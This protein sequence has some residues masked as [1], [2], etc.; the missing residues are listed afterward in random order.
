[1]SKA[2]TLSAQAKELNVEQYR[3]DFPILD[4][5]VNGKP[6]A[7]LD[8]A[9]TTQKPQQVIDTLNWY[10]T[11][12]NSNVHRGIHSLSQQASE[13]YE[14]VRGKLQRFFNAQYKE[15][16]VFVRGTTEGINL[17]AQTHGKQNVKEGDE[18]LITGMEHHSNIVPWQMLCEE[19]GAT[20]KVA[21]VTD[22]G[23]IDLDDFEAKLS[24]RTRMVAFIHVSNTLGTVN[25]ARYLVDRAHA[26]G[27]AV[28]IDG[29]Q[30]PMHMPVDVQDLDCDFYVM[31]AHKIFG[32]TGIGI[33]YGKYDVLDAMPPYQG[34]GDMI[35]TVTFEG[36]SYNEV[37]LKLEAGTPNIADTIAFGRAVEYVEGIGREAI[38][39]YE[40][41]LLEYATAA[42][43]SVDGL[44]VIGQS[45]DKAAV[46]SFV[47]DEIHPQDVGILLDQEGVAIRTGHHCTQPLMRRYN[48][49]A[50]S[51]A[52]F[53]FYNTKE[54]ID[55]LV[56]AIHQVKTIFS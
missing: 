9:A 36:T 44:Q 19:Q 32:P 35:D 20:L 54:E 6:L 25:P 50:T 13:A 53:A 30:A 18:V 45:S 29:A 31:S 16:M 52:S 5:E 24:D 39:S 15:E 10:Y 37:P 56:K 28:L 43:R 21:D 27:A 40:K 55:Q 23:D 41:E 12:V 14:Q 26:K 4:Q 11:Q 17:V 7:Y 47:F 49:P 38:Q 51:R 22:E 42:L 8:N 1:M 34:G 3:K 48:I 2:E 33:L 46:I